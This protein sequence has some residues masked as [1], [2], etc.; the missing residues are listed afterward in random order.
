MLEWTMKANDVGL[1]LGMLWLSQLKRAKNIAMI[2]SLPHFSLVQKAGNNGGTISCGALIRVCT[3]NQYTKDTT[4]D[5][6]FN[7]VNVALPR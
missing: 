3:S 5:C 4:Q 2:Y 6:N 1:H 7:L